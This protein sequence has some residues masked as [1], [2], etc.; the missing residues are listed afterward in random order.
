METTCRAPQVQC[1][2]NLSNQL[3]VGCCV[4]SICWEDCGGF[5]RLHKASRARKGRWVRGGGALSPWS[6]RDFADRI[7]L[8]NGHLSARV[9]Q[10]RLERSAMRLRPMT[11]EI[12]SGIPFMHYV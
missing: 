9:S 11:G 6:L 1:H 3:H 5:A 7:A 4:S 2:S 8:T 10:R 12:S